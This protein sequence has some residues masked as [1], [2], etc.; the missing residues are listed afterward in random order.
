MNKFM[1]VFLLVI[2]VAGSLSAQETEPAYPNADLLVNREWL[3][4]HT[5]DPNLLLVDVREAG[6][7]DS[8][9]L[10]GAVYFD[11]G[12]VTAPENGVPDQV[13]DA[14]MTAAALGA[15][16]IAPEKTVVIVYGDNT[17]LYAARLFWILEYYG[18]PDVRLMNGAWSAGVVVNER[19][20]PTEPE[21]VELTLTAEDSRRVEGEWIVEHLGD[22]TLR[23]LDARNP[24]EYNGIA[25]GS[26]GHIPGADNIPWTQNLDDSTF[27]DPDALA[28]LYADLGLSADD[29]IVVYC[30]TGYRGA[31]L[32]FALRLLGYE[33][34]AL[35]D[36]SW[37][38]WSQHPE[39]G[40]E[41]SLP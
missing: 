9:H 35:Y 36:G 33:N 18:Y 27:L 30:S 19:P 21:P 26:A 34:V 11:V 41:T 2:L 38:E 7:Y 6:E 24:P 23:L 16:G 10:P 17:V 14:E 28:A 1:A 31:V 29:Q 15:A 22:A 32:Y 37:A 12:D 3:L 40:I 4:E 5:D 25:A 39:W 20:E 13:T 8:G